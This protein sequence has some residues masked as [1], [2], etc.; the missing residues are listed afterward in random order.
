MRH[1]D[2]IIDGQTHIWHVPMKNVYQWVAE[3]PDRV[4]REYEY[5]P[6]S[7]SRGESFKRIWKDLWYVRAYVSGG[8]YDDDVA[9]SF[10]FAVS[11]RDIRN[12]PAEWPRLYPEAEWELCVEELRRHHPPLD[13]YGLLDPLDQPPTVLYQFHGLSEERVMDVGGGESFAIFGWQTIAR[14]RRPVEEVT[15]LLSYEVNDLRIRDGLEPLFVLDNGL[16]EV[17]QNVPV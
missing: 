4:P 11:L 3:R 8:D 12:A 9:E 17:E 2:V 15:A 16:L 1:P 10:W 14:G 6:G 13:G 7:L 5:V